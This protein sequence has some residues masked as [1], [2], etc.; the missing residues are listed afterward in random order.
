MLNDKTNNDRNESTCKK[1]KIKDRKY[2]KIRVR[3]FIAICIFIVAMF[4][5]RK[6]YHFEE[7]L[8]PIHFNNLGLIL[9]MMT[10]LWFYFTFGEYLTAF[11]GDE[12]LEMVIF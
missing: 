2:I 6:F 11:Y 4:F 8:K 5:I 10:L 3:G 9:L 7:Y 12:P 1:G